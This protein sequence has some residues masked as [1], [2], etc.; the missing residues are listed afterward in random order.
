MPKQ[1]ALPPTLSPRLIGREAAAAYV[2]VSPNT[3]DATV[4]N[5][6]MPKPRLLPGCRRKVWDVRDRDAAVDGL[7]HDGDDPTSADQGWTQPCRASSRPALN[8]TMSRATHTCRFGWARV[9]HPTS[10]RSDLARISRGLRR[11]LNRR[12]LD[13]AEHQEKRAGYDWSADH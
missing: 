4:E 13:Q 10:R 1:A 2:G 5:G 12:N 3:F 6:T 8:A 7:P 11:R 9:A